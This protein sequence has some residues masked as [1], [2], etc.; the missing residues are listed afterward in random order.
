MGERKHNF[1]SFLTPSL[2]GCGQIHAPV[3]LPLGLAGRRMGERPPERGGEESP[4]ACWESNLQSPAPP[5]SPPSHSYSILWFSSYLTRILESLGLFPFRSSEFM[6]EVE[7]LHAVRFIT[8]SRQMG[9]AFA[10]TS[11]CTQL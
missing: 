10:S 11:F 8:S 6:S 3:V 2:D 5:F 9:L 1:H 7:V 4:Y